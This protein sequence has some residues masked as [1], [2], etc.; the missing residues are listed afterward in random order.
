MVGST[1]ECTAYKADRQ[2]YTPPPFSQ[3]FLSGVAQL[4]QDYG[5]GSDF[6][7]FFDA[8]GT[9]YLAEAIFGSR[10][11]F[12][13]YFDEEGWTNVDNTGVDVDVAASYEGLVS[14]G[15][16][17]DTKSEQDAQ[18]TFQ[19]NQEGYKMMSLGAQPVKGDPIAWARQ[20]I[21]EPMPIRY[22]LESICE[23]IPDSTTKSNCANALAA[24]EYCT[25]RLMSER[26]AM[27]SCSSGLDADC[28]WNSDC[29]VGHECVTG[30]CNEVEPTEVHA[31]YGAKRWNYHFPPAADGEVDQTG[32]YWPPFYALDRPVS[33]AK[34]VHTFWDNDNNWWTHHFPPAVGDEQ[35]QTGQ[36]WKPFYAFDSQI[37]GTELVHVY[38]DG[39]SKQWSFHFPPAV[40]NEDD[41]TGRYWKPFYAYRSSTLMAN[42]TVVRPFM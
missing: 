32:M 20:V 38:Y 26:S 11:G 8:F 22:Q 29:A 31:Y 42:A 15:A 6:F 24:E 41:Q 35:D 27:S 36:Y 33:G 18:Q 13:S 39:A 2:K 1:A 19:S 25:K 12:T 30:S 34:E 28:L 40:S 21:D 14:S 3:N 7:N 17:L 16:S 9:H 5:D 37:D 4:P 23:L 10:F